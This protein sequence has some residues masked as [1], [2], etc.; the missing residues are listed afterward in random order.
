MGEQSATLIS[1]E[2]WTPASPSVWLIRKMEKFSCE[3]AP[4]SWR[5][6]FRKKNIEECINKAKAV[7]QSI[8]D[9]TGGHGLMILLID[10]Y[11]SFSYNLYQLI[12]SV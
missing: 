11:D 9:G 4:A 1:P 6:V 8:G 5:T 2:T 10:N 7:S 12:G 3:A